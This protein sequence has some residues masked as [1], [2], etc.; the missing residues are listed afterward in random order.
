MSILMTIPGIGALIG[1]IVTPSVVKHLGKFGNRNALILSMLLKGVTFIWMF[2]VPYENIKLLIIVTCINA[3]MGFG[4]APQLSMIADAIDY[5]DEKTGVRSDGVAFAVYGLAT[6][7]GGAIGSSVG[8][9][10]IAGFGYVA[11][12]AVSQSALTGFNFTANLFCGLLHLVAAAIP[13]IFWKMTDKDA[14]DI[15]A[16]I[17]AR[18]ENAE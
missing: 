1:N 7:L 17:K 11:G 9:M 16:R 15:R 5:Q 3:I 6:K 2:F 10:L 14:D 13:F 8:I 18:N 4:F 12:E